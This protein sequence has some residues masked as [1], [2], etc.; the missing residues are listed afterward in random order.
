MRYSPG[1]VEREHETVDFR[2]QYLFC[3]KMTYSN[4]YK[5]TEEN[6]KLQGKHIP[7]GKIISVILLDIN[8]STWRWCPKH[9][10]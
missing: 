5:T 9:A 7:I 8:S 3:R 6:S 4:K 10:R 2:A 1:G